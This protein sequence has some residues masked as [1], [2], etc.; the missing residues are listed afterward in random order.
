[1]TFDLQRFAD[2]P[3]D[4]APS[5]NAPQENPPSENQP[6][7]N[8]AEDVQTEINAAIAKLKA[9]LEAER[10]K[11]EAEAK[12]E[13]E[14]LSKLSDDERQKAELEN[15]RRELEAQR[16]EFEREKV[17]YEAAKVLGQRGLPV[18][19]TDYLIAEDNAATLERI[20]TF[21]KHYRKAI[22]DAVNERLKGKAPATGGKNLDTGKS[23]NSF[24][25]AIY[26]NQIRPR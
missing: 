3:A 8:P 20:K 5:D 2:A 23:S 22:E 6:P 7:E 14:R 4:N 9:E 16:A 24:M 17:K 12:R 26:D 13:A 19:F 18:E 1:M 21:E 11:R 25:Q 10:K 15:T